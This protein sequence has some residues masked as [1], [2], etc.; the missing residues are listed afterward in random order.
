MVLN[1]LS[2][3]GIFVNKTVSFTR[4]SELTCIV[5]YRDPCDR[6]PLHQVC[7]L[8]VDG[9]TGPPLPVDEVHD[10]LV[11]GH[12]DGRVGDL[13]DQVGGQPPVQPGPALLPVH[14]LQALPEGAVLGPWLSQSRTHY[15]CKWGGGSGEK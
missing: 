15:L 14:Q 9:T 12:H 10:Q 8:R 11:G 13:P 5:L 1:R 2:T 6:S 3:R 7:P 4:K